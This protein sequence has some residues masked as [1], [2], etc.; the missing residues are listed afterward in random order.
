MKGKQAA[1]M[2]AKLVITIIILSLLLL[3]Y[4]FL[5]KGNQ[6]RV[7]GVTDGVFE[8]ITEGNEDSLDPESDTLLTDIAT[9][10]LEKSQT[11]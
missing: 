8:S 1:T 11:S 9:N 3:S 5:I 10:G 2:V 7:T 4:I 6:E